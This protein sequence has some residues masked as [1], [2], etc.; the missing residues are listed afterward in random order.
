MK[1]LALLGNYDRPTNRPTYIRKLLF[2][3]FDLL[4][5]K[6]HQFVILS[7]TGIRPFESHTNVNVELSEYLCKWEVFPLMGVYILIGVD[8]T[9]LMRG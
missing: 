6:I 8:A 1:L 2:K 7:Y 5:Q 3:I 9:P 4:P